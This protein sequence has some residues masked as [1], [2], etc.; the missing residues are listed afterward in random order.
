MTLQ[1]LKGPQGKL[2]VDD[3]GRGEPALLFVH[4]DCG[5]QTQWTEAL[6]HLR[7][8]HRAVAFDWRGLGLSAQAAN[9]DYSVPGRAEDVDAVIKGL[10]LAGCVLVGHSAG[11]IV[12]LHYAAAQPAR[13]GAL[14]LVDP[15]TDGRQ[16]PADQRLRM[17]DRLRGP[18]FRE[19]LLE[20]Y[21]SIAGPHEHVRQRVLH[22][23]A[24]APQAVV[25]A[26]FE[27]LGEYNPSPALHAYR[28]RRLSLVTPVTDTP[29]AL[30]NTVPDFPY[31]RLNT[32][33]HWPQ[34]D[35]PAEFHRILDEF[36]EAVSSEQ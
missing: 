8:R 9:G 3:G 23:A 7:S 12:A 22:D 17:L 5:N 1:T 33:G 32:P 24:A 18:S 25:V 11:G 26:T 6:D 27:A 21:G 20:Y 19:V 28:G 14:L 13:I 10:S 36:L 16:V 29:A 34:L 31:R 35:D 4:C 30:H 2:M 15:A